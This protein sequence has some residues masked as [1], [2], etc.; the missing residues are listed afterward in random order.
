MRKCRNQDSS[1]NGNDGE[2]KGATLISDRFG[3][4]NGA[5]HIAPDTSYDRISLPAKTVS[6]LEDFTIASWVRFDSANI[7]YNAILTV[8]SN[9]SENLLSIGYYIVESSWY[10]RTDP[11]GSSDK[12]SFESSSLPAD[13]WIYVTYVRSGVDAYLYLDG[14]LYDSITVTDTVI[15]ADD[16]GVIIGQEQDSLG[17]SFDVNQAMNGDIDSLRIY[18]R[19]LNTAEAQALYELDGGVNLV[20]GLIAHYE[21]EG[22]AYDSSGNGNDGEEFG[23]V[24]YVDGVMGKAANFDGVNDYIVEP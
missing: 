12:Y 8:G 11:S 7:N 19:A 9:N 18:S 23:G 16:G 5:Y 6:G 2:V 4:A 15:E 24:S 20:D 10:M 3:E 1:G 14:E 17:G 13:R 21:F 22:N